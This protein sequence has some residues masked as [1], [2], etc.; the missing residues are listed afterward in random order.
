L[1]GKNYDEEA[2]SFLK[3]FSHL[4]WHY[5][6]ILNSSD[7]VLQTGLRDS[8]GDRFQKIEPATTRSFDSVAAQARLIKKKSSR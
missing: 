4:F 8:K 3:Y 5:S 6:A 1:K 7:P 2:L